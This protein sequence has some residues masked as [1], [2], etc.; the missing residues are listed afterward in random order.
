MTIFPIHSQ[1][2]RGCSHPK[3]SYFIPSSLDIN[4]INILVGENAEI[5]SSPTL[6]CGVLL[7]LILTR[8]DYQQVFCERPDFEVTDRG[9]WDI[10]VKNTPKEIPNNL[11]ANLEAI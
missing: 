11:E 10:L 3:A 6:W 1:I 8:R 9:F 4:K 2:N 5:P 7:Y